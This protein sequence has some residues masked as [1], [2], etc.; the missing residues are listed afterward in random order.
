MGTKFSALFRCITSKRLALFAVA[1][2]AMAVLALGLPQAAFAQGNCAQE[3]FT[4]AGNTQNLG[5]TANDVRVAKAVNIRNLDGSARTT[6]I[7]GEHFS[8][9]ADFEIITSSNSS[10]S[11]I[12]LYF[13]KAGGSSALTGTCAD[14][15]IPPNHTCPGTGGTSGNAAITCGSDVYNELD[16]KPD[17]CGDTS[18]A[19]AGAF[20][21]GSEKV[22]IE[23]T[24]MLCS[25]PAGTNKVVLPNCTTWQ[26]PGKTIQCVAIAPNYDYPL[27]NGTTPEAVPGS[28]SKCNCDV[29]SLDITVQSPQVT[30]TKNCSTNNGAGT[31]PTPSCSITPEGGLVTYTVDVTNNSNFGSIVVDQICDNQYGNIFTVSGYGGSPCAAGSIGTKGSLSGTNGCGAMTIAASGHQSCTFQATQVEDVTVTDTVTVSGHGVSSGT[32][33]PSTSNSVTVKSNEAPS[34]ATITK[35]LNSV[36]SGCATVRYNVDVA[37]P[38]TGDETINLTGLTDDTVDITTVSTT[39]PATTCTVPHTL[40][41]G[42]VDYTCTFDRQFCGPLTTIVTTA[43]VC[44][45]GTGLCSAGKTGQACSTNTQCDVTCNGIQRTDHISGSV[46]DDDSEGHTVALTTNSLTVSQCFPTATSSSTTP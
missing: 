38:N 26:V 14:N 40:I 41:V 39:I 46:S 37:N 12:G 7:S 20:G 6:C 2:L 15:I 25:A 3:E 42:A 10:R 9:I 21:S 16:P 11:N 4:A 33:G 29:I 34:S 36:L 31:L 27:K 13:N 19:D 18:S 1:I 23:V 45:F 8:F 24:D 43:G 28:P 17:N 35:G 44:N 22:T 5:C 30:V 32:F